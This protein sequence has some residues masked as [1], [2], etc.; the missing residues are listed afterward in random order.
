MDSVPI[1]VKIG[2]YKDVL[3]IISDI[4]DKLANAK[5]TLTKIITLR[6]QEETEIKLWQAMLDELQGK[7][8][9]LDNELLEPKI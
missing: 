8:N 1:F 4:H 9:I 3:E 7:L 2:E 5:N 6:D